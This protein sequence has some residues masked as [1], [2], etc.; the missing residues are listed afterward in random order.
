MCQQPSVCVCVCVYLLREGVEGPP[1][2]LLGEHQ[3]LLGG[4][5]EPGQPRGQAVVLPALLIVAGQK[6]RGTRGHVY[7]FSRKK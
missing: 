3:L 4:H 1:E 5:A 6:L 7:M 2:E